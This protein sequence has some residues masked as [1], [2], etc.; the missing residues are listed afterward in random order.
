M[1]WSIRP[2]AHQKKSS[3]RGAARVLFSAPRQN[4][5]HVPAKTTM[6]FICHAYVAGPRP[7]PINLF[8]KSRQ[9]MKILKKKSKMDW[10]E[11]GG[12]RRDAV[13]A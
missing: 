10:M 8:T 9:E 13:I 3:G 12:W 5:D 1:K 11:R 6:K 2:P 4:E 7:K